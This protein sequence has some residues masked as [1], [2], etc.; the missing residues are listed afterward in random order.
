MDQNTSIELPSFENCPPEQM[1]KYL[2][3]Y[4]T[5]GPISDR[6][7]VSRY[8]RRL[9]SRPS[10]PKRQLPVSPLRPIPTPHRA[11]RSAS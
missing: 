11:V 9:V 6:R 8:L 5:G 4:L 10:R 2:A 1:A 7:I 3:R